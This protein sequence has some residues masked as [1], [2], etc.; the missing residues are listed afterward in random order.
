MSELQSLRDWLRYA[1]TRLQQTE[2]FFGHGTDNALDEAYRLVF[3][4][5][6]LPISQQRLFLDARLTL[7]EQQAMAKAIDQ[8]TEDRI[9]TAYIT[10]E[11]WF[12]ELPFKVTKD[13]LIPRSPIA[14]LIDNQ[15]QPWLIES[16]QRVLDLC[17]GSGC[18]GLAIAY[19]FPEAEVHLSDL[20][21][22]AL[23]V[24][25]ANTQALGLEEQVSLWQSD[26]FA[27]IPS[28]CYD[29]IVTN[30]PYVDRPD[31]DSLP[32]EYRH[33]PVL[34]LAAG[35][36]G[37]SL[38]HGILAHSPEYLSAQGVLICEV[39][40]SAQALQDCY[41]EVPFIWIEFE[42]GG[43]GVFMLDRQTLVAHQALF[44]AQINE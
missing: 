35:E 23:A 22:A 3:G 38:V 27:Q 32:A 40:N 5:L 30:P 19:Y 33:E 42:R 12:C 28:Q 36:D 10:G 24:A 26:L 2:V 17:T 29:L 20:S 13:T 4:V 39:G 11:S 34:A 1:V 37:L 43:D 31:M 7:A 9:P 15:F 16:P 18:I 44:L 14:E 21:E 41:P 6:S 8:R 25:K